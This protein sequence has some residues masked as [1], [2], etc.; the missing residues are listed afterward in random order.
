[1]E[2]APEADRAIIA[3]P[4]WQA[5]YSVNVREALRPGV[6]GWLDEAL[7]VTGRWDEID[8]EQIVTS[9]TWWHANE[10]R[11]CPISA[12]RRLVDRLPNASFRAWA[13]AGHLESY[14]REPDILD[15]LLARD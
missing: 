2:T 8:P 5:A 15:E 6:E 12:A 14:V 7:A 4:R 10:D 9:V 13:N 3:D 1:M 11:N